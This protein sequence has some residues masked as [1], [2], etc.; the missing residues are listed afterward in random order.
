MGPPASGK[1][2]QGERIASKYGIE[3]I[4]T[5]AMLRDEQKKGTALGEQVRALIEAGQ[6][7]PDNVMTA[8]VAD[9][10][11]GREG[12]AGFILDG[13][14]RTVPQ[15][16]ALDRMLEERG[17]A[18][19]GALFF[20]V[21]FEVISDRILGRL[22]CTGC[23]RIYRA[24]VQVASADV[25][26]PACGGKLERRVDDTPETLRRRMDEYDAKTAPVLEFYR[27]T[28]RLQRVPGE[29]TPDEV[30]ARVCQLL[31]GSAR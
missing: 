25:P 16:E 27:K 22:S 1:G 17:I 28:G 19:D 23:Q 14:P 4:S 26:C 2:T 29:G 30:F 31:E 12:E 6:L 20:D 5:G 11:G 24:G 8:L 21:P 9:W 15:A 18:I 10:I 7:V 3:A 13:F